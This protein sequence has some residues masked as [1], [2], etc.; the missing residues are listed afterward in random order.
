MVCAGGS[1]GSAMVAAVE[2]AKTLKA[3]QRCVVLLADGVRNYMSK[4]L[5]NDWM[6][7]FGYGRKSP[8]PLLLPLSVV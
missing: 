5:N 2:A 8:P 4:F 1:A 7:Q 6:W 3:G